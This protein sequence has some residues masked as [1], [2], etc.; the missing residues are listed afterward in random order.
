MK[1]ITVNLAPAGVKKEGAAFD[2]SIGLGI[3]AATVQLSQGRL[4]K[5][6]VLGELSLDGSIRKVNGILP[7]ALAARDASDIEGL[8]IAEGNR[9]EAAVVEGVNVFP[10]RNLKETVDFLNGRTELFP[11]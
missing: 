10:V 9:K 2:L 7:I 8:I 11:F 3:L 1:R 4:Q 6:I 5:Y